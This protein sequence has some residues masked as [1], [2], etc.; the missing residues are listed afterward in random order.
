MSSVSRL[1]YSGVENWDLYTKAGK[2]RVCQRKLKVLLKK[3][4]WFKSIPT[5]LKILYFLNEKHLS[6][7]DQKLA[8]QKGEKKGLFKPVTFLEKAIHWLER[9]C[10]QQNFLA[11]KGVKAYFFFQPAAYV[12]QS[13]KKLT[14]HEKQMVEDFKN[15]IRSWGNHMQNM[16][17]TFF[18]VRKLIKKEN[19]S[20]NL[21]DMSQI[22]L[23]EP[24][25]VFI[26]GCCH[27]TQLGHSLLTEKIAKVIKENYSKSEKPK[28]CHD[29]FRSLVKRFN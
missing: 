29:D 10:E 8:L 5:F 25:D 1:Y 20:L 18:L 23:D 22:F 14:D 16:T 26:D 21:V 7:L 13:K 3:N 2:T 6:A 4:W 19:L 24:R 17:E 12:P 27:L 11:E 15:K 9:S 28:L